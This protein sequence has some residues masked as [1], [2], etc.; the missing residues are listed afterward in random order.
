M[1][2]KFL[3]HII[4]QILQLF[5][6]LLKYQKLQLILNSMHKYQPRVHVVRRPR[7]RPIEQVIL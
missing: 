7:E 6:F 3:L 1:Y 2:S 4:I 5:E